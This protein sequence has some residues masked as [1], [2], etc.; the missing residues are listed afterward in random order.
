MPNGRSRNTASKGRLLKCLS[1]GLEARRDA[2]G[3]LNIARLH[4]GEVNGVAAHPLLLRWNGMMWEPK[5]IMNNR[6]DE[7]LRSKNPPA[8]AVES[9]K[10]DQFHSV[11]RRMMVSSET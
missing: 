11:G 2:V 1:C 9:V 5:R 7:N 10:P 4:G 8:L 3:V 6:A